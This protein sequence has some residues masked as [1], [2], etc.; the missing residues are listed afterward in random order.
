MYVITFQLDIFFLQ[1]VRHKFLVERKFAYSAQRI[2]YDFSVWSQFMSQCTLWLSSPTKF[3]SKCT[4]WLFS[5]TQIC[6]FF[7][8]KCTSLVVSWAQVYAT[9]STCTSWLFSRSFFFLSKCTS[10][11][12]SW[13]PI[14]SLCFLCYTYFFR[15]AQIRALIPKCT[16]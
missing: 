14:R 6:S 10:L 3:V 12:F 7:F 5:F 2:R 1:N 8:L 11:L 16:S 13:T 4:S 9:S 15:W